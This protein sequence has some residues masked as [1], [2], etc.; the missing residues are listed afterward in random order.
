M[1]TQG[2]FNFEA[3]AA[4]EGYSRWLAERKLAAVELARRLNL[5]LQH[6]VEVWLVGQIRLRGKLRLA[7]EMLCIEENP[8]R[9]LELEVDRVRFKMCEME[10][11]VRL[12]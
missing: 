2:E 10:L 5:P 6:E 12:D 1:N 9:H 11:C 8:W 4:G 3:G 7:E